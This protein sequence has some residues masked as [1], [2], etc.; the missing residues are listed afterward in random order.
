MKVKACQHYSRF[1]NKG[2][3]VAKTRCKFDGSVRN[4]CSVSC[5][6]FKP[7]LLAR[8]INKLFYRGNSK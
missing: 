4:A 3:R 7:T 6:H 8:I 1:K 2:M 5:P